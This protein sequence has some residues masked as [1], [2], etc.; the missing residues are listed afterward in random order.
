MSPIAAARLSRAHS[1][2]P[3]SWQAGPTQQLTAQQ[4]ASIARVS[5]PY[6]WAAQQ[7]A[8]DP[9]LRGLVMNGS[10]SLMAA[11]QTLHQTK[12][13]KPAQSEITAAEFV[14]MFHVVGS[15]TLSQCMRVFK[16]EALDIVDNETAPAPKGN[17]TTRSIHSHA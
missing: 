5:I 2:W 1:W 15:A 16:N 17:G 4:L 10:M 9:W 13:K 7:V 14:E 6:V 12:K 11:A 8:A 3:T